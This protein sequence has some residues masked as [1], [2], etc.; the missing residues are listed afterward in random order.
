MIIL[1]DDFEMG[2]DSGSAQVGEVILK[3][4]VGDSLLKIILNESEKK[5]FHRESPFLEKS[6]KEWSVSDR[7]FAENMKVQDVHRYVMSMNKGKWQLCSPDGK[8]ANQFTSSNDVGIISSGKPNVVIL[9]ESPHKSEYEYINGLLRP[10][11]PA[12]GDTGRNIFNLFTS[13]VIPVLREAGI[14]FDGRQSYNICL[15]N[16]VPF[17]T[18]LVAIHGEA[19]EK[20]KRIRNKVWKEIFGVTREDFAARLDKYQPF[21]VLNG[22]TAELKLELVNVLDRYVHFNVTHPSSWSSI[23]SKWVTPDPGG[24]NKYA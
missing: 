20:V 23:L 1:R 16:P 15:V 10:L 18:S 12:L 5:Q 4:K 24:N 11:S 7:F 17:Q 19:M 6:D 21:L 9:L 14:S 3:F 22:C 8:V 2:K 13:H